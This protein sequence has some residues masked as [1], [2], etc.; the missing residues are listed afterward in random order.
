MGKKTKILIA[1]D[2]PI[3]LDFFDLMLTKLGFQVERA[4]DGEEAL[5]KV[6][7]TNPDLILL[8]TVMPTLSGYRV[9]RLLKTDEEYAAY[10]DVPIIM[11]TAMDEVEDKIEGF[12]LGVEDYIIKPFNFSEV[13]ARI[14]AVLRSRQLAKALLQKE[15]RIA[16]FETLHRSLSY[17]TRHLKEPV[18][19]LLESARGLDQQDPAAVAQ[20]VALVVKNSEESLAALKGLED[21]ISELESGSEP[22]GQ[23]EINLADLEKKFQK[24]IAAWKQQQ[25]KLKEAPR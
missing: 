24:H 10:R 8:D 22:P 15:R 7:A 20:F 18:T 13:L 16:L 14:R 12:E 6:K 2:E 5:E 1:D 23:T 11:F 17:F 19:G 25:M 3:N 4:S 21:E 9:T